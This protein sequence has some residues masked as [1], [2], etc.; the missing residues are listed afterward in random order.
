MLIM[1]V[2]LISLVSVGVRLNLCVM[3][4][5]LYDSV[6]RLY[7]LRNMLLSVSSMIICV[8]FIELF[9]VLIRCVILLVEWMGEEI[10][11]IEFRLIEFI[12]FFSLMLNVW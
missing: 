11:V 2:D 6:V 5:M 1:I 7:V 10:G 9:I 3:L 8:W 12:G 4:L